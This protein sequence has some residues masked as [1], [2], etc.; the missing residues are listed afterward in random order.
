VREA[1]EVWRGDDSPRNPIH[2]PAVLDREVEKQEGQKIRR[3]WWMGRP[4]A[5]AL[6]RAKAAPQR[7]LSPLSGRP[8]TIAADRSATPNPQPL[9]IF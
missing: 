5:L 7:D 8:V 3:W 4:T 6:R 2:A 9:L 1:Q